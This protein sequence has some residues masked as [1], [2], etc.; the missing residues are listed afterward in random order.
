MIKNLLKQSDFSS[1][2]FVIVNTIY[3]KANWKFPFDKNETEKKP[4]YVN[5]KE[6]NIDM[7]YQNTSLP[8]FE[9][10]ELQMV[11][12]PYIRDYAMGFV[13]FKKGIKNITTSNL[14]DLN[15]NLNITK[16]KLYIPRFK[17][18]NK[19]TLNNPLKK[20][21]L[22]NGSNPKYFNIIH[23]AIVIVN[24]EGTEA[25]AATAIVARELLEREI[26][27]NANKPFIYYI[28]HLKT[29]IILFYG[30]FDGALLP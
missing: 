7:M 20:L 22:N 18:K 14:I 24:E 2:L 26:I 29:N 13:L 5:G 19:Y 30:I 11:E 4:F 1:A 28:R 25:S 3:F 6:I 21:G 15:K 9:N 23:E 27:F 17:Q 10:S 8:Y 12:L 16:I